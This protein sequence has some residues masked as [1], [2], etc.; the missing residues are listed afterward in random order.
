MFLRTASK[1]ALN[2]SNLVSFDIA[3]TSASRMLS[4]SKIVVVFWLS[5]SSN[6]DFRLAII[7]TEASIFSARL[8]ILRYLLLKSLIEAVSS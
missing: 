4:W 7:L 1:E 8:S 6:T 2:S 3:L 5:A